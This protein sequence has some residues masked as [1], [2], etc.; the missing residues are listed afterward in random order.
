[1]DIKVVYSIKDP[2]GKT[3][4]KL[5]YKFEEINEEVTDFKY[6]KGDVI[7]FICRHESKEKIPSLTLHY[8]GNP[9][10]NVF[11]GEPRKLGIAFPKLLTSIFRQ[12]INLN[13]NIRVS[14]E[15]THHGPTYQKVPIIFAEIGSS[16]EYW[17]NEDLIKN[18]IESVLK[19]I[20]KYEETECKRYVAGFGGNHYAPYFTKIARHDCIG[21]VISKYYLNDIDE[22]IIYQ[23]IFNSINKINTIILDNLNLN[24]RYKIINHL[25]NDI[26][27][28]NR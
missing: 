19:G 18:F 16:Y 21:H 24:V 8:P 22:K 13:Y 3:I 27:I 25:P 2:V 11:G 26:V 10:N 12:L 5:G 14:L 23:V 1:M 17:T 6:E 20:D 15:A 4:H 7:V 28:E 9:T